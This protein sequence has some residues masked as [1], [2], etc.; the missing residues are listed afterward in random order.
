VDVFRNR[1]NF[2]SGITTVRIIALVFAALEIYC[3]CHVHEFD[4]PEREY[5]R[6]RLN[7]LLPLKNKQFTFC[8]FLMGFYNLCANIPGMYYNSYLVNT[9]VLPFSFL[10]IVTFLSVPCML[11]FVPLWNRVIKKKSWFGTIS[12]SLILASLHYFML[13]FVNSGNYKILYTIAM[14]YY[15]SVI[16]G[17]SIVTINLPY[18][19]LP[20][21]DRV[22]FV[23]FYTGFNSF[24]AMLAFFIGSLFIAG[25]SSWQINIAG[26]SFQ[27]KQY[28]VLVTG[29]LLLALG[30]VYRSIA[31][32][33]QL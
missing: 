14:V 6:K 2:L 1:G 25:T 29:L 12:I 22:V 19:R 20:E 26:W 21:E 30:F 11:L 4:E 7:L 15:F 10:G 18:Y 31:K 23:A 8:V 24:M 28:I 32:R 27:N 5:R 9:L 13:P 33:E 17:V 16:P 3:H